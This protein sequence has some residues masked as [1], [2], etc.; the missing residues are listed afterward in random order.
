MRKRIIVLMLALMMIAS[1]AACSQTKNPVDT[2]NPINTPNTPEPAKTTGPVEL[3]FATYMFPNTLDTLTEDF[4]ATFNIVYNHVYDRLVEFDI[5]T[6]E[7][8]PAIAKSWES[9]DDTT[10]NFEINLDYKFSNGDQLTMDDVVYSIMRIKDVPKQAGTGALIENATYEGNTLTLRTTDKAVYTPS[11]ILSVAVI[12][13][14]SYV[15]S[16]GDDALNNKPIGTGPYVVT[17]FTP[18]ASATLE[19]W[20][21]YPFEKPQIDKINYSYIFETG[22]RYIALE[23]GLVDIVDQMS[24]YEMAMAKDA[25]FSTSTTELRQFYTFWINCSKPPFDNVNI[26]RA[27]AY[28]LNRQGFCAL[29]GGRLPETGMLFVGYDDLERTSGNSPEFD[30]EKARVLLE[31]EGYN[32]SNPLHVE[33]KPINRSDPGIEMYQFDLLTIGVDLTI[34]VREFSAWLADMLAGEFDMIFVPYPNKYD[35]AINDVNRVDVNQIPAN[36]ETRYFNERAQELAELIR[37]ETDQQKLKQMVI[38][39]QDLVGQEVPWIPIYRLEMNYAMDSGLSGVRID[40]LGI[41][42][43]H[44]A[45]FIR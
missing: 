15:E 16:V 10:W 25:G 21:G 5:G 19:Y 26:R 28:A 41:T 27:L 42:S 33:I 29:E 44:R 3:N 8:L 34:S 20:D 18:G 6:N 43:F 12:V 7:W 32:E 36:N 11:R 30:L 40:R 24:S 2:T 45:T 31:A 38:E 35:H 23:T 39:L 13:N 22:P 9:V 14:K 1:L 37:V 4:I 17:E